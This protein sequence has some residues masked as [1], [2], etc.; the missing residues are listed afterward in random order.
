M[1]NTFHKLSK[2]NQITT[3]HWAKMVAKDNPC[4]I[5][6]MV[7]NHKNWTIQTLSLKNHQDIH[8]IATIT[9]TMASTM[10]CILQPTKNCPH[11]NHMHTQLR[12][13]THHTFALQLQHTLQDPQLKHTNTQTNHYHKALQ[14]QHLEQMA[15]IPT[16]KFP[17]II[18]TQTIIPPIPQIFH[19]QNL[20]RIY[21]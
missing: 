17:L 7:F 19:K 6:I 18:S 10:A 16:H 9:P 11:H 13:H 20:Y 5:I 15:K 2:H 21:T 1:I 14:C 12:Y 4:N 8:T 3:S